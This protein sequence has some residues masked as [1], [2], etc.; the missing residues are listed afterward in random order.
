M[1]GRSSRVETRRRAPSRGDPRRPEGSSAPRDAG[2]LLCLFSV[3]AIPLVFERL[4]ADSFS[5]TKLA[6]LSVSAPAAVF[7]AVVTPSKHSEVT[8]AHPQVTDVPVSARVSAGCAAILAGWAILATVFSISPEVSILGA[9][10][11]YDGLIPLLMLVCWAAAVRSHVR[12]DPGLADRMLV[13]LGAGTTLAA[14]YTLLQAVGVDFPWFLGEPISAPQGTQGNSGINGGHLAIGSIAVLACALDDRWPSGGWWVA[15]CVVCAAAIVTTGSETGMVAALVGWSMLAWARRKAGALRWSPPRLILTTAAVVAGVAL[16][17]STRLG[18]LRPLQTEGLEQRIPIWQGALRLVAEDPLVGTGP[19]TFSLA[20][21]RV[22]PSG[23]SDET[24]LVDSAHDTPLHL[25]STL[26]APAGFAWIVAFGAAIWAGARTAALTR[27]SGEGAHRSTTSAWA[28]VTATYVV[29]ALGNPDAVGVAFVGWTALGVT[30]ATVNSPPS[31][32]PGGRDTASSRS[33][34]VSGTRTVVSEAITATSADRTAPWAERAS[35]WLRARPRSRRIAAAGLAFVITV[36]SVVFFARLVYAD[37]EF[38]GVFR[39][40]AKWREVAAAGDHA[41]RLNPWEPTYLAATGARLNDMG[42]SSVRV[43]TGLADHLWSEAWRRYSTAL[44]MAPGDFARMLAA[45][46]PLRNLAVLRRDPELFRRADH[47]TEQATQIRPQHAGAHVERA[48][49]LAAWAEL[50]GDPRLRR[51]A[52]RELEAAEQAE[53]KSPAA[54]VEAARVWRSLD[55]P[56]RARATLA[57][58]LRMQPG[59]ETARR[60]Q[61]NLEREGG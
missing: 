13:A 39:P 20:F 24:L 49:V 32:R 4:T 55:R 5:L 28:A 30:V 52:E 61:R 2:A 48:K 42:V 8:R 37:V 14:A 18:T 15:A 22:A 35:S 23:V 9:Y 60:M 26:G 3:F 40:R 46:K 57:E 36:A 31:R 51:E 41:H 21:P 44:D 38:R 56:D 50:E 6:L 19:G 43:S 17:A 47:L 33:K 12:R 10:R 27:A 7:F 16:L 34:E 58:I 25:A 45:A 11:R 29:Q 59:N 53:E 54:L 1:S